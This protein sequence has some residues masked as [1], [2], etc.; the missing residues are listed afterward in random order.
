MSE[1]SLE[2]KTAIVTGAAGAKGI[3]RATALKLAE[4]GAD[5]VAADVH[6]TGQDYNLEETAEAV[7]KLG[8]RS[9]A[10]K[11]DISDENSVN[12]LIEQTV[13][14]FGTIDIVVNNAGVGAMVKSLEIDRAYWD[15]MMDINVRGCHFCCLAAGRVM[16]EKKKGSIINISSISG[17][18]YSPNQY[19][20]G[21]SKAANRFITIWL[22][23]EFIPYNVRVNCIAPGMVE[24]EINAHD[25]ARQIK[26]DHATGTGLPPRPGGGAFPQG[27][28]CQPQ[29]VA[30]VALFLASD[31]SSYVSGQ[32]I[33]VDGGVSV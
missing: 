18:K 21:V 14:E 31:A 3:G 6:L 10:L 17:M 7:R 23:K 27:R 5:V 22:A 32:V 9:L 24:T 12:N 13:K 16:K 29:D 11:V 8:R 30:N 28:V 26:V 4:A 15:R 2:G 19:V 20:Y 1:F 25:L 33:V